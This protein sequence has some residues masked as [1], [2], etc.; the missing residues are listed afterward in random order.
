VPLKLR[1][2]PLLFI[3]FNDLYGTPV[4]TDNAYGNISGKPVHNEPAVAIK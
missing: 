2:I 3:F 4:N 1:Q